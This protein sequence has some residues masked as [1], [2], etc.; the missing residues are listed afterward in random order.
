MS[1]SIDDLVAPYRR[2][3]LDVLTRSASAEQLDLLA[4][5]LGL[6]RNELSKAN[7]AQY[8]ISLEQ[9]C[10][11]GNC[12]GPLLLR[13][14]LEWPRRCFEAGLHKAVASLV[15][16]QLELLENQQALPVEEQLPERE[17]EALVR[18]LEA[19]IGMLREKHRAYFDSKLTPE[20]M[21]LTPKPELL[22]SL[23]LSAKT[24]RLW[25]PGLP[26]PQRGAQPAAPLSGDGPRAAA[27]PTRASVRALLA[28]VL[29]TSADFHALCLD[30][31]PEVSGR[32]GSGMDATDQASLL[33]TLIEPSLIVDGLRES[34]PRDF[35]AHQHLLVFRRSE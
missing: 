3:A 6:N 9:S 19:A 18:F 1:M 21:A 35:Q 10:M 13:L 12:Y 16:A 20:V 15:L 7:V 33:L 23:G 27:S 11:S 30:Y 31:F 2:A 24:L 25:W 5:E 17:R 32:F 29:K 4:I 26:V 28:A 22:G 14:F 8:A 34:K